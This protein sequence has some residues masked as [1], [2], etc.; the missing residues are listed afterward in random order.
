MKKITTAALGAALSLSLFGAC[1][2]Q[3]PDTPNTP[4]QTTLAAFT[5]DA[6]RTVELPDPSTL[7]KISPSGG[8]SQ[9][10]LLAIAPDLMGTISAG[11][12]PDNAKYVPS[13][14]A[15]L[16]VVGQFYGS[17][18]INYESI[19]SIGSQLVIDVGEPK[20]T[21]VE[22]MDSITTNLAVPAVHI[23]ATIDSTPDAFRK[24]GKILDREDKGEEL[25]QFCE[26][27]LKQTDDIMTQVGDNKV[28]ILY[29]MGP[30][31]L[32]V[33]AA[34][35]FHAEVLDSLTNNVAVVNDPSSKGDGN[36]TD[37]EQILLWNP[38]VVIFGPGS[39]YST[40][41]SDPAWK[42]LTAIS[43]G[44]YYE[45][46]MGPYNWVGMPPSIN[47]YLSMM[48]FTKV[49]YPQFADFD[50]YQEVKEYYQLFYG[51]NLSQADYDALTAN[52]LPR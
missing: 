43:E 18:D 34:T 11:Y 8:L 52:S 44:K 42:Q 30:A 32:N 26:K 10:F 33:L 49:F 37:L 7:T 28:K 15:G 1:T 35:S 20:K 3:P 16:P 17:S 13:E 14:V 50:L 23:T 9:M 12:T 6:G 36:E 5:D 25:A 22:D 48:W 27:I 41:S 46:P 21:I 45:V 31:G 24:L 47:R 2:T 39:I 51:Y 19:A 4:A 40:V 29:A 38:D